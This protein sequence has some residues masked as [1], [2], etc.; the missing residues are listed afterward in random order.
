MVL[1]AISTFTADFLKIEVLKVG[2]Y[3]SSGSSML[4]VVP[5][6]SVETVLI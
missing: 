2:R 6:P 5:S 3:C 4:M 1:K